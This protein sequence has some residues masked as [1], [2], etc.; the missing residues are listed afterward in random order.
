MASLDPNDPN[1]PFDPPRTPH[2]ILKDE[3][4]EDLTPDT[5][6]NVCE[7]TDGVFRNF[8]YQMFTNNRSEQ[9]ADDTPSLPELTAF[10]DEP[11]A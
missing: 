7:Q 3:H 11:L 1:D 10:T 8:V 5:E 4:S 9:E 2:M 6:Q